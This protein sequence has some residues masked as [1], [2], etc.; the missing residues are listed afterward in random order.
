EEEDET[1][2]LSRLS[3]QLPRLRRGQAG[4]PR[5]VCWLAGASG[6][7]VSQSCLFSTQERNRFMNFSPARLLRRSARQCG[8]LGLGLLLLA[9]L[10]LVLGVSVRPA[11]ALST[12]KVTN[13]TSDA[14]LQADV[15]QAN[16]DNAGDV[17]TF[18]CSGDLKLTSTLTITGSMTL[19]GNG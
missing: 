15:A 13:C 16:H 8:R 2:L 18:A 6:T 7:F 10:S 14:Q 19:S 4:K 9:G 11:H 3:C 12:L 17:I 5:E 1:I